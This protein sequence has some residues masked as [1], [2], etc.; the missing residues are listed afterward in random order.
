MSGWTD[1]W[2]DGWIGGWT[3]RWVDGWMDVFYTSKS[4]ETTLAKHPANITDIA[5]ELV[6]SLGIERRTRPATFVLQFV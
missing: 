3:D 2:M 6:P 1:E 4:T 5:F